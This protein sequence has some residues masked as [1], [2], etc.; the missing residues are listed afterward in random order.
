MLINNMMESVAARILTG[1]DGTAAHAK[2]SAKSW[3]G[4]KAEVIFRFP[5]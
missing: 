2:A 4:P 1:S 5:L 3:P